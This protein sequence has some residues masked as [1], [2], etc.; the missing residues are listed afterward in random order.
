MRRV[1]PAIGVLLAVS[2]LSLSSAAASGGLPQEE[3][4]GFW[5]G[6]AITFMALFVVA[7]AAA[8][9]TQRRR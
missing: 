6:I 9:R 1:I 7:L 5:I 2:P 8:S 3:P 4:S